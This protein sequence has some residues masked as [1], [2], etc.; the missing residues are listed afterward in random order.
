MEEY[1]YVLDFLAQGLPGG[2]PSRRGPVCYAVGEDNFKLFELEPRDKAQISLGERVYIGKDKALRTK[3]DRVKRRMG[4]TELTSTAQSELKYVVEEIVMKGEK[5]FIE[6]YNRADYINLRKHLLEELPGIGKK[7]L[8][9][10]VKAKK[11]GPFKGFE[12]LGERAPLLKAPEKYIIARIML[13]LEDPD[14]RRYL[15]VAK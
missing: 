2:G 15:F 9:E 8:E 4:Y 13:E 6:F 14:R 11:A 3:I 1:A 12:D 7:S 10:F 5:K